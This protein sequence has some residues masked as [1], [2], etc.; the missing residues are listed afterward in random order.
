M[1]NKASLGLDEKD[2]PKL[3]NPPKFDLPR[4]PPGKGP[5]SIYQVTDTDIDLNGHVTTTTLTGIF[6]KAVAEGLQRADYT[7][8][9]EIEH[10]ELRV[11][12]F[13]LI[14]HR[15][16]MPGDVM[17]TYTWEDDV[18]PGCIYGEVRSAGV[19]KVQAKLQCFNTG[20]DSTASKL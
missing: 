18:T 20:T 7:S 8:I 1:N 2:Y 16:G 9:K 4:R 6:M 5:R 17:E 14:N 13:W 11:R 10:N 19:L 12:E 15:E 3:D